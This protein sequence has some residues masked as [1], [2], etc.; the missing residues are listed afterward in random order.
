MTASSTLKSKALALTAMV[1][2]IALPSSVLAHHSFA[3]FDS[4]KVVVLDGVVRDFQW[5][6]PHSWIQLVV[7]ESGR[8]T[9]YSIEMGSPNNYSRHGWSR[10]SLKAGDHIKASIH[11]R[12]DGSKGGSF[13]KVVK[14]DG[15]VLGYE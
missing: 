11:P 8:P 14:A 13:V 5:T 2:T 9:E 4:T 3:M 7:P 1:M 15:T 6:N 12:K 10:N